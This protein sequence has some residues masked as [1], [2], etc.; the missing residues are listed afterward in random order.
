MDAVFTKLGHIA[1]NHAAQLPDWSI[2]PRKSVAEIRAYL[3]ECDLEEGNN[4]EQVLDDILP[5]MEQGNVHVPHPGYFGLFN[6][7]T[8]PAA[9][10]GDFLTALFNPQM[11]AYSHAQFATELERKMLSFFMERMGWPTIPVA[12]A[13]F[14]SGGSE[15][16]FT[17]FLCALTHHFPGYGKSGLVLTG[18]RPVF[19]ASRLA[20][21]SF[22]KIAAN[23]GV[24]TDAFRK[25]PTGPNGAMLMD[26]LQEQIIR[27]RRDGFN[28]F[29]VVAT[30]GSTPTGSIDPLPRLADL[31]RREQLWLHVDAAWAGGAILSPRVA[32]QLE[33][34]ALADSVTADAHKW[35][36]VPMGAGMFYCKHPDTLHR[37]FRTEAVYMPSQDQTDPYQNSLLWSRRFIGLKVYLAFRHQGARQMAQEIE[38]QL[39]LAE[40]LA[41]GLQSLG[42]ELM[43]EP[44]LGVVV[45]R[46]PVMAGLTDEQIISLHREIIGNGES[47]ISLLTLDRKKIFR[48]CVTSIH[49]RENHIDRLLRTLDQKVNQPA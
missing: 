49:S 15:A 3:N 40:R 42:W 47:W 13:H 28:P 18:E 24:G 41:H 27:D 2:I 22:D 39:D 33:G 8:S 25:I 7:A 6:P 32:N 46:H 1:A 38:R 30:A 16:N 34:I 44:S 5:W 23:S 10:A 35:L 9:V 19:Y 26:A 45:F 37:T 14:T 36:A 43:A 4:L 17:G 20:H 48:A 21:N 31:C 11:A 12:A 29:L